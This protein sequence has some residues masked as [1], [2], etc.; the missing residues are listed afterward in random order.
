M[1]FRPENFFPVAQ[2]AGHAAL[3]ADI[4]VAG[5]SGPF[6]PLRFQISH[7]E[8]LGADRITYGQLEGDRFG[9]TSVI[10]RLPAGQSASLP[11]GSLH[12]FAVAES[13]LRF[14]DARTQQRTAP[15]PYPWT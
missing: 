10:S 4:R 9:G 5:R 12:A 1:G 13:D 8:Y 15:K 3:P 14:F 2:L 7:E 11:S 6:V